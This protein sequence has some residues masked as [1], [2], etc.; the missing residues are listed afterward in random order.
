[1]STPYPSH[2]KLE[3]TKGRK[4]QLKL[5]HNSFST[6]AVFNSFA[7]HS[8]VKSLSVQAEATIAW[9]N[10]FLGQRHHGF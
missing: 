5:F 6:S 2:E 4:F 7:T 10:N 8:S 3:K 1:M 9:Y